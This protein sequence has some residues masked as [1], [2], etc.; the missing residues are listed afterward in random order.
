MAHREKIRPSKKVAIVQSNYI[1]W[2]G[3]FDLINS[4]EEFILFDDMQYTRRDWRNRNKIKTSQGVTWLTIPVVVKGRYLQKI[5]DTVISDPSWMKTHWQTVVH[6]Y[7]KA[8]YFKEY[9]EFFQELYLGCLEPSLSKINYRFLTAICE[10]LGITTKLSWSMD[11]TL[12]HDKTERLIDLCKQADATEYVSGPTA[13]G[14]IQ[15]ELFAGENILLSYM[16]YGNY[17]VYEQLHGPFEHAVS[18]VDL[19]L[20]EGPHATKFMKSF[21]GGV[22][23]PREAKRRS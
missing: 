2:K 9:R 22:E 21:G 5:K 16:D 11:Y 6:S 15:E 17:P 20:N 8:R 10:I 1:P 23:M 4:V 12:A 3:Y 18:V 7:A 13:K 14:Y 19:L